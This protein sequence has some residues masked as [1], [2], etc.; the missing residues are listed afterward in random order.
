MFLFK[1]TNWMTNSVD[2]DQMASSEAIWSG[3]TL[4]AKV[5]FVVNSRIRVMSQRWNRFIIKNMI[6]WNI[7]LSILWLQSALLLLFLS[8]TLGNQNKM[9]REVAVI[10]RWLLMVVWLYSMEYTAHLY[11]IYP[12]YWDTINPNHTVQLPVDVS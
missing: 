11:L 8:R 5:G 1:S 3:S 7:E 2:P 4:F 10:G 6:F 9:A 12:K